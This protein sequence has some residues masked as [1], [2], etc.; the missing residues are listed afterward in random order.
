MKKQIFA[1]VFF[2]SLATFAQ[3][4]AIPDANFEDALSAYDDIPNDG[5]VPTANIS[6]VT[7]LDVNGRAIRDLTGIETF[8]ALTELD[9]SDN[10]LTYLDISKNTALVDLDCSRNEIM[11]L[12]VSNNTALE[13]LSCSANYLM[14]LDVSKNTAL[15]HLECHY[16]YLSS[17]DISKNTALVDLD[18]SLNDT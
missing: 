10:N 15:I 14:S 8:I 7:I 3:Y 17:L 6:T 18:C 4:T 13:Q 5:Q 16:G 12:D 9:C 2:F 11:S 1:L